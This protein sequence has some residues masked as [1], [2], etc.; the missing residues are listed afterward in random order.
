MPRM[1]PIPVTTARCGARAPARCETCQAR[2]ALWVAWHLDDSRR[3]SSG[4]SADRQ[5][6]TVVAGGT[7]AA[8]GAS[9][10]RCRARAFLFR[11]RVRDLHAHFCS[12]GVDRVS[13]RS[14]WY[15]STLRAVLRWCGSGRSGDSSLS[16]R[17]QALGLTASST[18][19]LKIWPCGQL[20]NRARTAEAET[21]LHR[22]ALRPASPLPPGA[23]PPRWLRSVARRGML[24][25]R[26]PNN[27]PRLQ[28]GSTR[29]WEDR[30]GLGRLGNRTWEARK[31]FVAITERTEDG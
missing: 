7:A 11:V 28:L 10:T 14:Q 21:W 4:G 5:S 2:T 31:N 19:F 30:P 18:S 20:S 23:L 3:R 6:L 9:V 29:T 26:R 16:I 15:L 25:G 17:S 22:G 12:R 27:R 24:C 1:V 13:S 8:A